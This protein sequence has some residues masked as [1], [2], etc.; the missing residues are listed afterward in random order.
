[1]CFLFST[2]RV[3]IFIISIRG[4]KTAPSPVARVCCMLLV[5]KRLG[6]VFFH[7]LSLSP[8]KRRPFSKMAS[9]RPAH[10]FEGLGEGPT[11][12][13]EGRASIKFPKGEVF[14]NPVQQFN[15]DLS[16]TVIK[17]FAKEYLAGKRKQHLQGITVLEALSATGLRSIRY[18]KEIPGIAKIIANDMDSAAVDLIRENVKSNS[19][20]GSE[21]GKVILPNQ[22][23]ANTAMH[24][25][26]AEG[27]SLDV[28]DLDPYGSAAPFIDSA[29][30]SV[31]DG[32]LLC[33]TC[34][35]LAVLCATRQE[36]CFAKYGGLPVKG[37]VCHEAVSQL[38]FP[39]QLS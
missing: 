7:T 25:F 33:V 20:S 16:I 35:D 14:Y 29:V 23:D 19:E 27:L 31:A 37:D 5:W 9:E 1:M 17:S 4:N 39:F 12:I 21:L 3:L 8:A 32:G 38:F 10:P 13:N 6:A 2:A 36:T 15:R 28:V 34:T 24:K 30:Q 18:A 26:K 11:I 22:D